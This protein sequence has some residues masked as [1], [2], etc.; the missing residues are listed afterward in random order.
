MTLQY[1][2]QVGLLFILHIIYLLTPF[3]LHPD[4]LT[5][6]LSPVICEV[7]LDNSLKILK[8]DKDS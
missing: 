3:F 2:I 4:I 5:V 8:I 7:Y 6:F 1:L